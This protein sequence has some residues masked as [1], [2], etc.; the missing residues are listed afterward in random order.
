MDVIYSDDCTLHFPPYEITRGQ[1]K[2]YAESPA[3]Y[4]SIK[5]SLQSQPNTFHMIPLKTTDDYTTQSLTLVHDS[6]YI[7]FLKTIYQDWVAAGGPADAAI[8]ETFVHPSL[9]GPLDPEQYKRVASNNVRGKLGLY[10]FDLSVAYTQDT[11]TSVYAAAQVAVAAADRLKSKQSQAV[12]A[13]CR[14]P[15]HHATCNTAGG[16]CFINNTA[17]ATRYLQQGNSNTKV[18]IIDVDYHHGNGTQDV[19]YDDPSVLYISLHGFPG[20]PYFTGSSEEKGRG[21]GHGYNINIP[22]DPAMTTD[23]SYLAQLQK[24]LMNDPKVVEFDPDYV[25][26]SLGLDTWHQDPV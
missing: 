7:E 9:V 21:A 20:Y 15:G 3:R 5:T 18:L 23:Q 12:Y 1:I 26:C 19:F 24:V 2:K 16:Y 22:L 25:V 10:N 17:V 6:D 4:L 14:P 8:A 13:L 11:W